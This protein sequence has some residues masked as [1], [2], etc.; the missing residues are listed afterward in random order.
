[1]KN[2]L[3]ARYDSH[4]LRVVLIHVGLLLL[5]ARLW[6][7]LEARPVSPLDVLRE[8]RDTRIATDAKTRTNASLGQCLLQRCQA[9][10]VV[11]R[12]LNDQL[13][14]CPAGSNPD[15][16]V[17]IKSPNGLLKM[18]IQD[19]HSSGQKKLCQQRWVWEA[20]DVSPQGMVNTIVDDGPHIQGLSP[21]N[22]Q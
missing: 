14:S 11:F 2:T 12:Q 3:E 10:G 5:I 6:L 19:G 15:D 7:L 13:S 20:N 8:R 1:M 17:E 9:S 21:R 22:C 16:A 4:L 18:C